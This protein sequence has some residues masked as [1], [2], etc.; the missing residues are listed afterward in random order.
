MA[1]WVFEGYCMAG[2]GPT[3][4]VVAFRVPLHQHPHTSA[5]CSRRHGAPTRKRRHNDEGA[6]PIEMRGVEAR[7]AIVSKKYAGAA[8]QGGTH[9]PRIGSCAPPG[10]AWTKS[11]PDTSASVPAHHTKPMSATATETGLASSFAVIPSVAFSTSA[12][13]PTFGASLAAIVHCCGS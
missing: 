11:L 13:S 2:T 4:L 5:Q 1:H 3:H 12:T 10:A 9:R 8:Q 7:F 6:A